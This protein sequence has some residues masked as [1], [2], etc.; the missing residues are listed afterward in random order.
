MCFSPRAFLLGVK[1]NLEVCSWH[2]VEEADVL[3]VVLIKKTEQVPVTALCLAKLQACINT[4]TSITERR[5]QGQWLEKI[6]VVLDTWWMTSKILKKA[7]GT[8]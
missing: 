8:V 5:R 7:I 2:L 3:L 6:V 4:S 1:E